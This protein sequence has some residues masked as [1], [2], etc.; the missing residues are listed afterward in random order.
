MRRT[1]QRRTT[2]NEVLLVVKAEQ[3]GNGFC[4]RTTGHL[5]DA[6]VAVLA[7]EYIDAGVGGL[8]VA[9]ALQL[10]ARRCVHKGPIA[11]HSQAGLV[12]RDVDHIALARLLGMVDAHERRPHRIETC[13]IVADAGLAHQRSRRLFLAVQRHKARKRLTDHVHAGTRH[14]IRITEMTVTGNVNNHQLRVQLE[15]MFVGVAPLVIH[16]GLRGLDPH[17]SPLKQFVEHIL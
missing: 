7:L 9:R 15:H 11:L 2:L 17:V 4:R 5:N 6:V 12:L 3:R 14:V 16:A 13:K 1:I 8:F 10:L